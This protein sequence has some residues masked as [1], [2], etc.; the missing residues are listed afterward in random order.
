MKQNQLAG[1]RFDPGTLR[2]YRPK[3]IR[4]K[5]LL[6]GHTD[7]VPFLRPSI[8]GEAAGLRVPIAVIIGQA[9]SQLACPDIRFAAMLGVGNLGLFYDVDDAV[10]ALARCLQKPGHLIR[11]SLDRTGEI[12]LSAAALRP[13][14]DEQVRKTV[15]VQTKE[16]LDAFLP[17]LP[18][19]R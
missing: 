11:L 8:I 4:L 12:E 1:D 15:A 17:P 9:I 6:G 19:Q 5:G 7:F 18:P 3:D 2:R 14:H 16:G 13:G 10:A